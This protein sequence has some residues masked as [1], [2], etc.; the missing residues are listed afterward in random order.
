VTTGCYPAS[1]PFDGDLL[2]IM[3]WPSLRHMTQH[4][5]RAI[6]EYL[7]AIPCITGPTMG[8]LH[9]DCI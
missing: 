2:Q 8:V 9:N 5:L 3:P 7:G 6:Y 1:V 4:E